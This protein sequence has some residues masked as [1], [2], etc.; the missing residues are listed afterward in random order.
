MET[1]TLVIKDIIQQLF[2]VDQTVHLSRPDSQFG[3]FATNV[4]MQLA[5]PLGKSPRE[6][7][8]QLA[9]KLRETS[10]SKVIGTISK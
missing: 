4:A 7:A 10:E 9:E 8:E 6:I 1:I 5:K 2:N 3:D